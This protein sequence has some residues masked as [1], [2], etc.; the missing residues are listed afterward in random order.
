M[1]TMQDILP[2]VCFIAGFALAWVVLRARKRETEAALLDVARSAMAQA[3]DAARGD[4]ELRQQAIAE[5]VMPVRA[6]LDKVDSKIQE[7][8][9]SRAGAALFQL[10]DFGIHLIERG[11]HRHHQLGDGL[12]AQ[13][14]VPAR[15]VLGLRHGRPCH[16]Q[17]RRFGLPLARAQHH[18]RQRESGDKTNYRQNVLH[19]SHYRAR[20]PLSPRSGAGPGGRR[21]MPLQ[22]SLYRPRPRA[23]E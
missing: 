12:L 18:P 14:E 20:V 1:R 6:S 10:L 3:Q 7:L 8:E 19:G 9:K 21:P 23:G 11:S 15:R 17:K 2:V 16:I 22:P 5:L 13:F 4:L